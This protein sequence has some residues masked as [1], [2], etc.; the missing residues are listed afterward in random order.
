MLIL[1]TTRDDN[2][3]GYGWDT[4]GAPNII[5]YVS[6]GSTPQMLKLSAAEW[7]PEQQVLLK[8]QETHFW[9]LG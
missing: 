2:G 8:M 7:R 6:K 1:T 3:C 5:H 9:W 4:N